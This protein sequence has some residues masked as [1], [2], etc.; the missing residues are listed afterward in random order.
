MGR[1]SSFGTFVSGNGGQISYD[2]ILAGG[3][4]GTCA[5]WLTDNLIIANV[6]FPDGIFRVGQFD[7]WNP[8]AGWTALDARGANALSAGGGRWAA[9][10]PALGVFG[11]INDAIAGLSLQGTDQRGAAGSDGTLATVA[12]YQVGTGLQL[13]GVEIAPHQ[14]CRN[15]QVL[16]AATAVWDGG[17][18][19]HIGQVLP[20]QRMRIVGDWR[21]Y[22]TPQWGIVA[23][24][25]DRPQEG[26]VI[27][28]VG[29][30][31]DA[32]LVD[33]RVLVGYSTGIQELPNEWRVVN[34]LDF[35]L[36]DLTSSAPLEPVPA[37]NKPCWLGWFEFQEPVNPGP[38][39]CLLRV[40]RDG[41]ISADEAHVAMWVQG[42][43]VEEIE[44]K[45]AQQSLPAVAYWDARE[46][47][48]WPT[49]P[50]DAW[51]ALQAYQRA[52]ESD[53]TFEADLRRIITDASHRYPQVALVC[54]CY[55]SNTGNT[56]DLMGLPP[57]YARLARDFEAVTML[58][59]FSDEGRAT[60][61]NDHPEMRS[62]WQELLNGI[63]GTP[64]T[65]EPPM[66]NGI[67]NGVLVDPQAYFFSLVAGKRPQDY[68]TVLREI[69]MD[70]YLY[71]IGQQCSSGG[72]PRGRLYLPTAICPNAKPTTADELVLGVKQDPK[73]WEEQGHGVNVVSPD[74][75][76]W[77]WQD[78]RGGTNNAPAYQPIADTP[79]PPDPP[80]GDKPSMAIFS[81]PAT[82]RR[83]ELAGLVTTY[84]T[85]RPADGAFV[86]TIEWWLNDG[87]P[88]FSWTLNP[89]GGSW[90]P[91]EKDGPYVPTVGVKADRNGT[92]N[93]FMRCRTVDGRWS[94]EVQGDHTVTVTE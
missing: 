64:S 15:A 28:Q 50:T 74:A 34:A 40:K 1:F 84:G 17:G 48:R 81:F 10:T 68:R 55:T 8:G 12:N 22:Y 36:T 5:Q 7:V 54:Q 29:Y 30:H 60:G 91:S 67:E 66:G 53:A 9:F 16:N 27:A 94:D 65:E 6:Q 71:G 85:G 37:I 41:L 88:R 47:P 92:W 82:Y 33:G 42:S 3:N 62:R 51:I 76:Q 38:H 2:G 44:Q 13:N 69:Q 25:V 80:P 31:H 90:N 23:H 46:W 32:V 70:L 93:L 87:A 20:Y 43:S 35:A 14:I 4:V 26:R 19:V 59:V 49:L 57:I 52:N 18:N 72:E 78:M 61:L 73:C 39:N 63:T 56:S 83:N 86:D 77:I 11:H 75:T 24:P 45:A 79:D 21:V 89:P 58:L